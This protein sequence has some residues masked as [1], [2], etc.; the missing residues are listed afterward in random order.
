MRNLNK[1]VTEEL[2]DLFIKIYLIGFEM[3]GESCIFLI[4]SKEPRR[5]LIYSIVMDCY[6]D[7]E[8]NEVEE[9]CKSELG[10]EKLDMLVWSHPH[11][12]HTV[13]LDEII[14]KYCGEQ[15]KIILANIF[16]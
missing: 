13:G 2:K 9:I 8:I 3:Q 5:K 7:S 4:Y 12:D 15:T 6:K 16:Y 11:D 14:K 1:I 10:Q